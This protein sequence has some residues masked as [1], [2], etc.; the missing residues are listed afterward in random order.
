[1]F[2]ITSPSFRRELVE[3]IAETGATLAFDAIGGGTM[4]GTIV[5]AMEEALSAT[6]VTARRSTS[7]STS[8]AC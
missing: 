3:A 1:M 6:V 2:S 4:A 7:R 8:T 5:T